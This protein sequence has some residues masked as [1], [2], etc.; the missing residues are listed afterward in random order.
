MDFT[1]RPAASVPLP[2]TFHRTA[3]LWSK[4]D[5]S[6]CTRIGRT[7]AAHRISYNHGASMQLE[8]Q[9]VDPHADP[10]DAIVAQL[11]ELAPRIVHDPSKD[12]APSEPHVTPA[13]S[14]EP[15]SEPPLR[16]AP[17]N[18]SAPLND[19]VGAILDPA[20]RAKFG[21]GVVGLIVCGGIAAAAAW[22]S[23]GGDAKQRLSHLVPQFFAGTTAP[24]QSA[25]AAEPQD[26]ATQVTASEP[27]AEPAPTRD[28][29]AAAPTPATPAEPATTASTPAT[30]PP[31]AQAA[32]SPELAQSIETMAREIASL[33]QTVEQL[34]AGQQQLSRD[35]A[36]AADHEA[37]RKPAVQASKPAAAPRPQRASTPAP[38]PAP[39]SVQPASTQAY[40]QGQSY[41]PQSSPQREAYIPPAPQQSAPTQLPPPPGDT[42]VPR[43][44]MPLR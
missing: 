40:P 30:E 4:R 21:R 28:T 37:R 33:K 20:P 36:K 22:H 8:L 2:Q 14:P 19:N 39:R 26:A 44:P 6:C 34:Q 7:R 25:G 13:V 42:S 29:T 12:H 1:A 23:Y 11:R 17:L 5:A 32:L 41:H 35:V 24:T 43:P 38:A 16:A 3:L 15:A 27:A 31:P 9:H 10:H 18:N